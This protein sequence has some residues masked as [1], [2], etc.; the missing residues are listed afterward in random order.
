MKMR[1]MLNSGILALEKDEPAEGANGHESWRACLS[2][3]GDGRG[4]GAGEF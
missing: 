3:E 1:G 2:S 4:M